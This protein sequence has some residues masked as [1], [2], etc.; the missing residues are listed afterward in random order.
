MWSVALEVGTRAPGARVAVRPREWVDLRDYFGDGPV[1][2]LF[3]P[4]AF[5]ST[6]TDE[7]CA[8]AETWS[9]WAGIG[10]RVFGLSVDSPYVNTKFAESTAAPFPILSDFNREAGRAYDVIRPDLGGLRDVTDRVVFVVDR[11]G[12]IVYVWQGEHPG[13]NP[14]LDEVR[15]AAAAAGRD[16]SD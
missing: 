15:A 14:P 10:A 12:T 1:V 7:M 11:E 9:E 13:V 5:S 4:M 8:V 16:P 2:L 6:C 3:F